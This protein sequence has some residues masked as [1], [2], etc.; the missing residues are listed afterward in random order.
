MLRPVFHL[1]KL[2]LI[3]IT[4]NT[5]RPYLQALYSWSWVLHFLCFNSSSCTTTSK[6][7]HPS[8]STPAAPKP[9]P[10]PSTS[11]KDS[12]SN[13]NLRRITH[14][15]FRNRVQHRHFTQPP[16]SSQSTHSRS[17]WLTHSVKHY[18]LSVC[19]LRPTP[20]KA[21]EIISVSFS[22][23]CLFCHLPRHTWSSSLY[24]IILD[25]IPSSTVL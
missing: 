13:A 7:I 2:K 18:S 25:G 6:S 17:R 4:V 15:L 23:I 9:E 3:V 8:I 14:P 1:A 19:N 16:H 24:T 21:L 10:P 22:H 12:L 5:V 11:V 20:R